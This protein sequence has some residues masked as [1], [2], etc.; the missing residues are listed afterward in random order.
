MAT[1]L[2]LIPVKT[3]VAEIQSAYSRAAARIVDVLSGLD[4]ATFTG[5]DHAESL[6]KVKA[7][8]L[9]LNDQVR[10]WAPAAINAAYQESAGVAQA[11]LELIGAKKLPE[12][13]YNSL[14]HGKKISALV[15]TVIRDFFKANL[16]I[17]KTAKKFLGV[18]A[19]A[20]RGVA[21]VEAQVQEFDS[22]EIAAWIKRMMAASLSA[23]TK[24]NEGM[25]HLTS[26][27]IAGKIM[28][29]LKDMISGGDFIKI[30]GRSFN[31]KSYAELVARTR[32]RE[33]GTE[34]TIEQCKQY[35]ND[36][37]E[38]PE[39]A[40]VCE[41]CIPHIGKVFSISGTSDTYPELPDGG[42]PWHPNDWCYINATSEAA[43]AWRNA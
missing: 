15:K 5:A 31:L 28:A 20:A 13:K 33:A 43:L 38:I 32:M 17:E 10:M 36:L 26:G 16:T 8:V 40:S 39:H 35:D 29:K 3:R 30:N 6:R 25:A 12:W 14:R 22:A 24:Y 23:K 34:A 4:P 37:V 1:K 41:E 11:R 19:Q 18:M 9:T 42:P 2:A 7:I 27:D 21:E